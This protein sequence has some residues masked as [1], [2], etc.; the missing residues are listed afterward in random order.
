MKLIETTMLKQIKYN[1]ILYNDDS[2]EDNGIDFC[3]LKEAKK[4]ASEKIKE[5]IE[6]VSIFKSNDLIY[7][8]IN[9]RRM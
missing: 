4:Y 2:G 9:E 7:E 6:R 5:G 3:T 8:Y 1:T